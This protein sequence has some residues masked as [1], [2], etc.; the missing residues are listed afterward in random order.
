MTVE[1]ISFSYNTGTPIVKDFNL[2]IRND[3]RIC[4]IGKNG[5]GKTTLLRLLADALVPDRGNI[6]IHANTKSGYFAQTNVINL[7]NNFTV[8][9]EISAA[10]CEKQ[11]ARNIAGAMMFEGDDALKKISLLSGGEKSRVLLGKIL[12][13]PSNLIFLD[14]PTNHLDMESC[15]ALMAAIDS[16]PGAVVMVT[17]NELFLHT[18]ANRFIVFQR[19]GIILFEGTY[20]DFLEKIG[21]EEEKGD[22]LNVAE[23]SKRETLYNKKDI[24]KLRS[25]IITRRSKEIK[26]IEDMIAETENL[27]SE[28]E[29]SLKAKNNELIKVSEEGKSR[30]IETL[31]KEIKTK[32]KDIDTLFEKYESLNISL[33][34]KRIYFESELKKIED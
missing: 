13:T 1:D 23:D 2:T 14:E 29:Q 6:S 16:F 20:S 5:R 4:V 27:I 25:D 28:K 21:W 15:D 3:D 32:K 30:E 11:A 22:E 18:L 17:H 34:E 26:P 9:E 7:N 19:S 24:R 33:D 8:E 10:G 12:A 31:S